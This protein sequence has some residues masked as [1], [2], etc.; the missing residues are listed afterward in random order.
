MEDVLHFSYDP[1]SSDSWRRHFL[2]FLDDL[3]NDKLTYEDVAKAFAEFNLTDRD[4]KDL[5]KVFE[6]A[7]VAQ[8]KIVWVDK[9]S[10]AESLGISEKTLERFKADHEGD[11]EVN[12]HI[13]KLDKKTQRY[14]L[15][16][17]GAL[18]HEIKDKEDWSAI[19]DNT[20]KDWKLDANGKPVIVNKKK[21]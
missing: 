19:I 6:S 8:Q 20:G 18:Y 21:R 4:F 12:V 5:I 2:D 9:K 13:K 10:M 14:H 11:I 3:K 15:K 16:N 1:N 7:H 17:F